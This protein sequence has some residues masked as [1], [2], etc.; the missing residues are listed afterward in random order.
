MKATF[1]LLIASKIPLDSELELALSTKIAVL[2]FSE[3]RAPLFRVVT[4]EVPV[5]IASSRIFPKGSLKDVIT[6]KSDCFINNA[7][8]RCEIRET[9]LCPQASVRFEAFSTHR[10]QVRLQQSEIESCNRWPA[11]PEL[12]SEEDQSLFFLTNLPAANIIV[13]LE[14]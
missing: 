14:R 2:S 7:A 10:N 13:I 1:K 6:N 5:A 3:C 4:I 12:L 11:H 8:H 9:E